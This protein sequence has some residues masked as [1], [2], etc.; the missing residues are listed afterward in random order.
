[1]TSRE[2]FI[3]LL[4]DD[5]LKFDLAELDFGIYRILNYRRTEIERFLNEDLPNLI[6]QAIGVHGSSRLEEVKRQLEELRQGLNQAAQSFGLATAFQDGVLDDRLT[7]LPNG[8]KYLE[9]VEELREL[10][11]QSGFSESEEENLYKHLYDFFSRY[12][13]DGDFVTQMRRSRNVTYVAPYHGEDVHFFWKS[14]GSHYVK[15]AEELQTYS[16]IP[17]GWRVQFILVTADVEKDN[18][19]GSDRFFIP[20]VEQVALDDEQKIVTIPFEF[21]PLSSEESSEYPGKGDAA[22]D[23]IVN[24]AL[25]ALMPKLPTGIQRDEVARHLK[26]YV[27]KNRSDYFVHPKL[28]VFL[29]EELDYYLK[30]FFLDL[31]AFTSPEAIRERFIKYQALQD[32]GSAIIDLLDQIESFQARLFEK[33]RFV[34]ETSYLIP[35]RFVPRNLWADTL[36]N[37]AQLAAWRELFKLEGDITEKTLLTYPTLVLNTRYFDRAFTIQA[38]SI[39]DDLDE[40][41]DGIL[42]NGENYGVLR[43]LEPSFAEKLKVVCID[44]PYNRGSDDFLYK[45]EFSRH[46]TWLTMMADR[47]NLGRKLLRSDGVFFSSIDDN[48]LVNLL[49]LMQTLW[50]DNQLGL[51]ARRTKSGGGSAS[52]TFAIE[53][54]YL[55]AWSKDKSSVDRL[56]VPYDEKYIQRYSE[57][58]E[59]GRYYWDTLSRS[60]TGT[61]P[62]LIEAPDGQMLEGNWFKS[63]S[64][65][66]S[67]KEKGD[68][69]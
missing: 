42:V 61:T 64:T 20:N 21:R 59:D 35:I 45:D 24:V 55:I 29:N 31:D 50:G 23:Q 54:D 13:R 44:P 37:E 16:F 10:E 38:L 18:N 2:K 12:Y 60:S 30:T 69:R 39:F 46:S 36:Q 68:I 7:K 66:L 9:F 57:E 67:D 28:G 51:F 65:F 27:R 58:D 34:L 32:I 11:A 5:I 43:T 3:R 41:V 6:S 40:A 48:E 53:H 62:Y 4:R 22:Q 1:M 33:R 15:T 19:K 25:A 56:L 63:E 17:N 26:R 14:Y 47:L 49:R 8:Q 52:S